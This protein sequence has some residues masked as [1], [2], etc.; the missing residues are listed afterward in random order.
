MKR[1]WFRRIPR[2]YALEQWA[3]NEITKRR[4]R[5]ELALI[6][7]ISGQSPAELASLH[8]EGYGSETQS[9]SALGGHRLRAT[10]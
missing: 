5:A 9:V 6:P 8:V 7:A 4:L 10:S 2:V 3:R 1:R